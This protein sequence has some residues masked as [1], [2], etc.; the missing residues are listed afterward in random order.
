[1]LQISKWPIFL[2]LFSAIVCFSGS[3][4]FHTFNAVN[5]RHWHVLLRVDY[6]G[7]CFI[8]AGGCI[9]V[10]Y[11]GFYCDAGLLV[12]Y[13]TLVT[14]FCLAVFIISLFSFV[15]SEKYRSF[16]G[17][18]YLSLGLAAAVPLAH[19]VIRT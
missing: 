17:I 2:F 13:L 19:L 12:L 6:A 14:F 3:V 8:I 18:M 11:Y 15:H 16:K 1:M 4:L 10:I 9:P 7:I 5:A